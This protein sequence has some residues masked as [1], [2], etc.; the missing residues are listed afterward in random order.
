MN[1]IHPRKTPSPRAVVCT[2]TLREH[3]E[4]SGEGHMGVIRVF[5]LLS[6]AVFALRQILIKPVRAL[7]GKD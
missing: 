7:V 5:V 4:A 3:E 2:P 6:W 1:E